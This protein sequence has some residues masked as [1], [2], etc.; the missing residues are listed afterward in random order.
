M[1]IEWIKNLFGISR[2]FGAKRSPLW[3]E[4]RNKH[5]KQYPECAVCGRKGTLLNPNEVHHLTPVNIDK[6]L[7]L[8]P[9]NL[10]TACPEDHFTFFHLKSWHS[11]NLDGEVDAKIWR[12]KISNRP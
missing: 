1:I 2:T 5:I 12:I 9:D 6:G 4:V 11:Y 3:R 8:D 10:I 7:E